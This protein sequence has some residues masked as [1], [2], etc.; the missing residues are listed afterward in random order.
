MS[1]LR[2]DAARI[3]DRGGHR[4]ADVD[5]SSGLEILLQKV[6]W[7]ANT[8]VYWA[9][10]VEMVSA[11]GREAP[12]FTRPFE[13]PCNLHI[14]GTGCVRVLVL[15]FWSLSRQEP[16]RIRPVVHM[17]CGIIAVEWRERGDELHTYLNGGFWKKVTATV[18]FWRRL[19]TQSLCLRE[20]PL[21]PRDLGDKGLGPR[22]FPLQIKALEFTL[23]GGSR[24]V[25]A[26]GYPARDQTIWIDDF[27]P[28]ADRGLGFRDIPLLI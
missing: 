1:M 6:D 3:L 28:E 17:D 2:D 18:R 4:V 24:G 13:Q 23:S 27:W 5:C 16:D 14:S 7:H 22:D 9:Y 8:A 10:A 11:R 20:I 19:R 12:Q 25:W 15:G 21:G 26:S